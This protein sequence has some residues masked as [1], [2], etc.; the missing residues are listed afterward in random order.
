L[1]A[2]RPVNGF[3][4][5]TLDYGLVANGMAAYLLAGIA[6]GVT[7]VVLDR[8]AAEH[9]VLLEQNVR[10][11]ER[12]ARY[13][14]REAIARQI[15]DSVLQSLAMVD[16][17]GREL[18]AR[19]EVAVDEVAALA[20]MAHE[21][22]QELRALIMR[23][24]EDAPMG[25]SSLRDALEAV[26]RA[27]TSIEPVVSAGGPLH[28]PAAIVREVA[29]AVAQAVANIEEHAG[30]SR[31]TIFAEH[32]HGTVTVT[33]RDDGRGFTYDEAELA[34]AGK[35]GL[36]RSIKGRVQDLGG[37]MNVDTRPGGGTEIELRVRA[38]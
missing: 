26:A 13:A 36:L 28:L 5:A 31:A 15:H 8:W 24:P 30:A 9:R 6:G 35:A 38:P 3:E 17:R 10:A 27:A 14:E 19:G 2:S 33:V 32:D 23:A 25:T 22:E 20:A 29:A 7:S 1:L 18:A 11:R 34:R 4:L 16:K 37:T 12:A 21:Q